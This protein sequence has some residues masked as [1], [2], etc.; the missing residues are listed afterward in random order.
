MNHL[1]AYTDQYLR[2]LIREINTINREAI[3]E[4]AQTLFSAQ[5]SGK[6]VFIMGN[7]GSAMTASHMACD[8]AKNTRAPGRPR[9]KIISLA[10]G[11]A[12]LTAYANDEGYENVFSEPLLSLAQA[13]DVV[14]A[15][16]GSG[17]SPNILKGLQTAKEIGMTTIGLTG[18]KGGKLK[19]YTDIC[20]IVNS[21]SLERIEDA[22]LVVNHILT[23]LLRNANRTAS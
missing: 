12:S 5:I 18:F 6:N 22:H 11:L 7:G 8:L 13:G 3:V 21:D 15:I 2:Q 1:S 4:I 17:N 14:I 20:L 9:L 16:S 19:D 10:D 23:G